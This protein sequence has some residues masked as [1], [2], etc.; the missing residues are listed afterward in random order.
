MNHTLIATPL[1]SIVLTF[2][3]CAPNGVKKIY[4]DR[5]SEGGRAIAKLDQSEKDFFLRQ[6]WGGY[7][8][9]AKAFIEKAQQKDT[10]G[11]LELTSS[12]TIRASGRDH[13]K[14]I[15]E[16]QVIPQFDGV[17]IVWDQTKEI[18]TD[19]RG[20]RGFVISGKANGP[21]SFPFYISVMKESGHLRVITITRKR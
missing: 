11:M 13:S 4:Y 14:A 15:Y 9:A 2:T 20:N 21:R 12:I 1:I 3:A 17:H 19:D 6:Q 7:F 5:N 10:K 16:S 18:I 8:G